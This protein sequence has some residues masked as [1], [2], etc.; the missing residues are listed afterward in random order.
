VDSAQPA[1]WTYGVLADD[2]GQ[3]V[4]ACVQFDEFVADPP[5]VLVP[6]LHPDRHYTA[7]RV[8]PTPQAYGR[9]EI[10]TAWAGEGLRLSGAVLA[11]VGLPPPSRQPQ[12]A[13][14]IH[15]TAD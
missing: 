14:V 3:A 11:Q 8:G 1:V 5:P 7:R 6:G 13:L 12:S 9:P 4:I 15:L 2:G 10:S